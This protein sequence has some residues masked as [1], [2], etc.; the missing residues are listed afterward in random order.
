MC[1]LPHTICCFHLEHYHY[2][3]VALCAEREKAMGNPHDL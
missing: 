1:D 2:P 3:L